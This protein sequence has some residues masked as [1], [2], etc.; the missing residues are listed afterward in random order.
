MVVWLEG[1]PWAA[2]IIGSEGDKVKIEDSKLRKIFDECGLYHQE[3]VFSA[4]RHPEDLRDYCKKAIAQGVTL[5]IAG[6]GKAAHLPGAIA[7]ITNYTFPV[8]GVA[9]SSTAYKGAEDAML[10][11]CRMPAGCP[12]PFLGIDSDGFTNAAMTA[13]LIIGTRGDVTSQG[14]LEKLAE[15]RRTDTAQ[16]EEAYYPSEQEEV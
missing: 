13:C 9:I 15:F 14:I 3:S 10:S 4:H 12:V 8:L 11:I 16:P 6:A 1:M 2:V 5:F 7:T